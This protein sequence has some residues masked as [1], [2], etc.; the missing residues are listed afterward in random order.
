MRRKTILVVDD[1]APIRSLIRDVLSRERYHVLEAA[2]GEQAAAICARR[3]RTIDLLV[4]DVIM[5]GM[6]GLTL[7]ERVTGAYPGM[8]VLY[9]S[10]KCDPEVL[11]QHITARG[12]HFLRKPF[13]LPELLATVRQC[14][15]GNP[16]T[17]KPPLSQS[18]S[19]GP[20]NT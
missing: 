16:R 10:A 1:E 12:F 13:E 3:G 6:D 17:K 8:R 19:T 11:Q 5:P 4:T 15:E 18:G 20:A 7:S 14:L 2:D 9:I